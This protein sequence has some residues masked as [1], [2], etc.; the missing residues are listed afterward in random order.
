MPSPFRRLLGFRIATILAMDGVAA[1]VAAGAASYLVAAPATF[2][3]VALCGAL[4]LALLV[5]AGAYRLASLTTSGS[6]VFR[7]AAA[8]CI[9]GG[10][11]LG[12]A[13]GLLQPATTRAALA[14]AGCAALLVPLL[15]LCYRA[16]LVR[17]SFAELVL[18]IGS[19][20]LATAV[21]RNLARAQSLGLRVAGHLS[22]DFE[23]EP[24]PQL[25]P[26]LGGTSDFEKVVRTFVV[27][28]VVVSPATRETMDTDGLLGARLSGLSIDDASTWYEALCDRV[29]MGPTT[30]QLLLN[31]EG[32]DHG[33]PYRA[34]KRTLDVV[35]SGVGLVLSLPVLALIACAIKLD[36]K[37]P[38][39]YRQTRLGVA[40]RPFVLFKLRT[41]RQH[42][43]EASGPALAEL[44]DP[45]IT[46]VGWLLRKIR[47]DE[48]PQLW[49]VLRGD[50]SIVG[51]RPERPEFI[52]RLM[53]DLELFRFRTS[54]RPGLTGWAQV[55]QGYVNQWQDFERKLAYDLFYLKHRSFP[56]E[57]RILR[58]TLVELVLLKG[59]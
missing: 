40:R 44:A 51:P 58:E 6:I 16:L 31:G 46:R 3:I 13:A 50:M 38:V 33:V 29:W 5:L 39:L 45:R 42:A 10:A 23:H 14:F 15:S 56:M 48:I 1:L 20:K 59:V 2:G 57:L 55:H 4:L 37:G 49:N 21:A 53:E 47:I 52:D 28:R 27:H 36:S 26:R 17:P 41:M 22:D 24:S 54:V 34:A 25:G 35:L 8:V 32:S 12:M 19:D 18:I 43:E 9:G 30:P 11:A 7:L